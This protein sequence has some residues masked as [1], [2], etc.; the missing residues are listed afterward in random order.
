[1]K[2]SNKDAKLSGAM[3]NQNNRIGPKKDE[4][5]FLEPQDVRKKG[6]IL[7]HWIREW[8]Q[9]GNRSIRRSSDGS[10]YQQDTPFWVSW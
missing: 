1:M 10:K 4:S 9:A 3:R 6:I 8:K 2:N 7:P 5:D